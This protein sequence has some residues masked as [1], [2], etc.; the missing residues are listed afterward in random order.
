[1]MPMQWMALEGLVRGDVDD[2]DGDG[3]IAKAVEETDLRTN[4]FLFCTS[5]AV[6]WKNHKVPDDNASVMVF[7]D[8]VALI[9]SDP[10]WLL[11][12]NIQFRTWGVSLLS[13]Q[14][15]VNLVSLVRSGTSSSKINTQD[16]FEIFDFY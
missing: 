15:V 1:M 6:A 7:N 16:L 14:Q 10:R 13:V 11:S 2:G 3:D 8:Q 9:R 4:L 5:A 12:N